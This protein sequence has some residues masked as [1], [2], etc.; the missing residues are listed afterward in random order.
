[1]STNVNESGKR[2]NLGERVLQN[3][4]HQVEEFA[5][6][7]FMNNENQLCIYLH[8]YFNIT[9]IKL[10]WKNLVYQNPICFLENSKS[11]F[12]QGKSQH[13]IFTFHIQI[14]SIRL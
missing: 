1:M 9:F 2:I 5:N 4:F 6:M 10:G 11:F 7:E 13:L 8:L 3:K 12:N 14:L